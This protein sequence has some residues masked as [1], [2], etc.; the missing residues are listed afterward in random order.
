MQNGHPVLNLEFP[1]RAPRSISFRSLTGPHST[2]TTENL[3][4][5]RRRHRRNRSHQ[6][7]ESLRYVRVRWQVAMGCT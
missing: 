7:V 1:A 3:S 4:L 6:N 5:R 2:A